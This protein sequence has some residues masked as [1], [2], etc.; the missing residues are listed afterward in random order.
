MNKIFWVDEIKK[1]DNLLTLHIFVFNTDYNNFFF[2]FTF[3]GITLLHCNFLCP[4]GVVK[5][6]K[7]L[8]F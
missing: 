2:L 6:M 5:M 1:I 7:I 3:I 8:H 4:T